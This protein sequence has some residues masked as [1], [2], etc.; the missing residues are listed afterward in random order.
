MQIIIDN[1]KKSL[2]EKG[3][4]LENLQQNSSIKWQEDYP[5]AVVHE[6]VRV[7]E[8]ETLEMLEK[9]NFF[10]AQGLSSQEYT[11]ENLN[12]LKKEAKKYIKTVS[13]LG[14]ESTDNRAYIFKEKYPHDY[15]KK[16]QDKSNF[17]ALIEC[18]TYKNE[19]PCAIEFD[20]RNIMRSSKEV[21]AIKVLPFIWIATVPK[22]SNLTEILEH[23]FLNNHDKIETENQDIYIGWFSSLKE[24]NMR[25]F[26]CP[27]K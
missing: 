1:I 24:V 17:K 21:P 2:Q 6:K 18:S 23:Y 11:T 20:L 16:I 10:N 5:V 9:K 3:D 27:P 25:Y 8:Q 13:I 4:F 22:S 7:K 12:F 14:M 19:T 15:W 26:V